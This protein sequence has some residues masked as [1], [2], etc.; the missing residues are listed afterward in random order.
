M[1]GNVFGERLVMV[2]FGESHGRAVGV[3]IDGLPAGLKLSEEDVQ[4]MLDLRRPSGELS[5][6]RREEDRVEIL[7]GVYRGRTTGA[8]LAMLVWNKDV[9]SSAY[10][11]IEDGWVRPGHADFTAYM[12]YGG[13]ND[14][15][16]SGRFSARVTAGFVMAGAVA[17]KLLKEALGVEVLAYVK[18]IAGIS[19]PELTLEQI[20]RRYEFEV[21]CPHEETAEKMKRAI[22]EAKSEG[23]SVGGIVECLA[24]NL[25]VGLGEPVFSALDADLAK[26]MFTIPAVKGVE[27][28]AGFR[29]SRLRG[30]ENNDPFT[31]EDGRVRTTK[32][33]AGGVLGGI[34]TGMP[35]VF[36]VAFKPVSSIAKPQRTVNVKEMREGEIVVKGRHDPC[37]VPRAVP[38]VEAMTAFVLADHAIRAGFI[39]TVLR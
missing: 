12:K 9:D 2:S 23:D 35:L 1:T 20:R 34:S 7:S 22:L 33:D 29:A 31:I 39:P 25:P 13:Y 30:S 3:V 8:P 16:G 19:A 6:A 18:E 32:N 36:R 15:R 28:G 10:K 4:R 37:V 17:M 14:P 26:A 27:F 38:I 11:Q 21:R 24:L 5:T